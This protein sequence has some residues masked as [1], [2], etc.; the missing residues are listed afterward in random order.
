[1]FKHFWFFKHLPAVWLSSM[2]PTLCL[3][4]KLARFVH[5]SDVEKDDK[6]K[7]SIVLMFEGWTFF[8]FFRKKGTDR[9]NKPNN[10][11]RKMF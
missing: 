2:H 10:H 5:N 7:R 11:I 6:V 3:K 1:M 4:K 9:D 8:M